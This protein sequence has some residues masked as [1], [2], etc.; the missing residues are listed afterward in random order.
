MKKKILAISNNFNHF[1]NHLKPLAI[2]MIEK[3]YELVVALPLENNIINNN[4]KNL[5]FIDF[6]FDRK[7]TS[8]INNINSLINI[9]K[10]IKKLKPDIII[11]F[12]IKPIF[13]STIFKYF[14][15]KDI[16]I[17]NVLLG[18]GTL[19]IENKLK[20]KIA[21]K[22]LVNLAR[23]RPRSSIKY[24]VQNSD[25]KLLLSNNYKIPNVIS[26]CCV[27]IDLKDF[28]PPEKRNSN[29][30]II[31]FAGRLMKDK[32]ILEFLEAA[33]KIKHDNCEFWIVGDVDNG[34]P[35]SIK[36]STL[37]KY[38]KNPKIIYKGFQKNMCDI[39]QQTHIALLPSYR[40]GLSR[41]LLEAAACKCAIITTDAPG[42][43]D[44][45][46]HDIDGLLVL[47]KSVDKIANAVSYYLNNIDILNLHAHKIYQKVTTKYTSNEV[48]RLFLEQVE[49]L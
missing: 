10:I 15:N 44:L 21:R 38:L 42:G 26:L 48:V 14:I 45:V 1:N 19:F 29:K 32:G 6:N 12:T 9:I 5:K 22:S 37:N 47:P 4:I 41:S 31:T 35:S 16:K 34:N 33:N 23:F 28:Y 39:W 40:E 43:R 17:V 49:S 13:Y 7:E 11:N 27:G 24:I 3:D 46:S 18:L 8:I 2:G 36:I 30:I 20:I 25:D